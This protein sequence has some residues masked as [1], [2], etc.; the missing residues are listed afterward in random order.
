MLRC[1]CQGTG[2]RMKEPSGMAG[3]VVDAHAHC[4]IQDRRPPQGFDDYR[5]QLRGSVI[6]GAVFFP[7]V[8]EIYDRHDPHFEDSPIWQERRR[9]ANAYLA[10][11]NPADF[12]VFP[13]FFMWNDFAVQEIDQRHC[14]IKWHRHADEPRYRYDTPACRAAID[15]IRRRNLPVCLEEELDHTVRFIQELAMGVRVI[16]PHL[17]LLNGGYDAIRARCL[18]ER[19]GV[20]A[21]TSLAPAG[22][23]MDYIHTYGH[24]RLMFGSDFPFGDSVR[25]LNKILHLPLADDVKQAILGDNVRRLLG[26]L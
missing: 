1:A 21:D 10:L 22:V 7:P 19:P 20:Y 13:Y 25:E 26:K 9:Q 15:E 24:Q 23:I 5:A 17:G 14:G 16:I 12:L 8:I 11:L 3:L 2:V 18:W 4:G 6:G